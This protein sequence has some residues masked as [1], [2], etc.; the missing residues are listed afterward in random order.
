MADLLWSSLSRQ[1]ASS[2]IFPLSHV[3]PRV[4]DRRV[5][6][7]IRVSGAFQRALA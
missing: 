2:A 3:V 5:I 1:N 7:G 4:D 6:G